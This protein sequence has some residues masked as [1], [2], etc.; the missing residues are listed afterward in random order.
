MIESPSRQNTNPSGR[1][2]TSVESD[3]FPEQ[4]FNPVATK[5]FAVSAGDKQPVSE[6]CARQIDED[7]G[8]LPDPSA[9]CE[10]SINIKPSF[11]APDPGKSISFA[12][13]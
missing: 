12:Q 1:V 2:F 3:R 13:L 8:L 9:A 7:K 4:S 6:L 5:G 10:Q 11:Q